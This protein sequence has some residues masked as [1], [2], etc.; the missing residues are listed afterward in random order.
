MKKEYQLDS[1]LI[2]VLY[3]IGILIKKPYYFE[4]FSLFWSVN[5]LFSFYYRIVSVYNPKTAYSGDKSFLDMDL[6]S[7]VIRHRI[8]QNDI[9][10]SVWQLLELFGFDIGL[11]PN[12]GVHPKNKELSCF[13]LEKKLSSNSDPR[14]DILRTTI[15]VGAKKFSFLKD[16][17][18]NISHYKSAILIFGE[19]PDFEFVIMNAAGT[20]PTIN[21]GGV[22]KLVSKNVFRFVNEQ[23]LFLWEW[24]NGELTDAIVALAQA[25]NISLDPSILLT[26]LSGGAPI[27]LFKEINDI[28]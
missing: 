5:R 15:Q 11:S 16:Q 4:Q 26:Q 28:S 17:R 3:N 9:A 25:N 1:R 18:D 10:Y 2:G 27:A 7:Y 24:M 13:D 12:G 22:T 23:H 20:M 6:E 21:S 14:L 8:I 19:G